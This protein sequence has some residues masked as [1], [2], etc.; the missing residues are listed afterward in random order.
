MRWA[1]DLARAITYMHQSDPPV[2][3]RDLRPANL[4]LSSASAIKVTGFGSALLLSP[5]WSP[6]PSAEQ[7]A[8]LDRPAVPRGRV[9]SGRRDLSA[10]C[11][12]HSA[13]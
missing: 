9:F 12:S 7:Q 13:P 4:L 6:F 1:L 5:S 2:V 10:V 3:H 8:G 11:G